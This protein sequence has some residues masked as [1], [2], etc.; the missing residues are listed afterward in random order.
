MRLHHDSEIYYFQGTGYFMKDRGD[1]ESQ[2]KCTSF[3]RS[4]IM[5]TVQLRTTDS[6]GIYRVL[7]RACIS[8]SFT[9]YTFFV[10]GWRVVEMALEAVGD[11][12]H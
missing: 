5:N 6:E 4:Q 8:L 10:G 9:H 11:M 1:G 2:V 7:V 12:A 3:K